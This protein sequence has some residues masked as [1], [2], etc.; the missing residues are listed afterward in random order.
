VGRHA[1]LVSRSSPPFHSRAGPASQPFAA[2]W[3]RT[4]VS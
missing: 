3:A 1:T 4:L 2:P